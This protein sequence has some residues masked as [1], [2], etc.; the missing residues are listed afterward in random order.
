MKQKYLYVFIFSLIAAFCITTLSVSYSKEH[1][2]N[3][4]NVLLKL[5]HIEKYL[6]E[7]H[8]SFGGM[9]LP[10]DQSALIKE[11]QEYVDK[12]LQNVHRVKT[13]RERAKQKD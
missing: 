5:N 10:T 4:V 1:N 6:K 8:K 12:A 11:A 13:M 3:R 2:R 9:I 7:A